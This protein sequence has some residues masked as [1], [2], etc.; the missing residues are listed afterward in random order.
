MWTH[1]E[2]R[3]LTTLS[4]KVIITLPVFNAETLSILTY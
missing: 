3:K 2:N 4:N 1:I